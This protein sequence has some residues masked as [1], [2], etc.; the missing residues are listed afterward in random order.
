LRT[1]LGWCALV[2]FWTWWRLWSG[3]CTLAEERYRRLPNAVAYDPEDVGVMLREWTRAG[4]DFP[5]L[6]SGHGLVI[7]ALSL[8]RHPTESL[9]PMSLICDACRAEILGGLVGAGAQ[10]LHVFLGA[11]A[12]VLRERLDAHLARAAWRACRQTGLSVACAASR[13]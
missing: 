5:H 7:A 10:V 12:G 8:P 1:F 9:V 6:L 11:G 3:A 13:S 2:I 4:G